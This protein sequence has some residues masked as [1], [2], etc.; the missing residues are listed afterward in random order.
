M[1]LI[2]G[3]KYH[4]VMKFPTLPMTRIGKQLR[5]R[6]IIMLPALKSSPPPRRAFTN[7]GV[8]ICEVTVTKRLS[9]ASAMPNFSSD[10]WRCFRRIKVKPWGSTRIAN[11]H[12]EE[13][14][15]RKDY[16]W[17]Y[18][19]GYCIGKDMLRS[20]VMYLWFEGYKMK[21]RGKRN[22]KWWPS[23]NWRDEDSWGKGENIIWYITHLKE[24]T[25]AKKHKPRTRTLTRR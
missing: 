23:R 11:K 12:L 24:N 14:P 6:P 2:K 20:G 16:L 25:K 5:L 8:N 18:R 17:N 10:L 22:N 13:Q 3:T 9:R 21:R 19:E 7:S 4:Q 15:P 1:I